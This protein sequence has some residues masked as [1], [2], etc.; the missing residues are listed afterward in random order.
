MVMSRR[1]EG[2]D[3]HRR[4]WPSETLTVRKHVDAYLQ[5]KLTIHLRFVCSVRRGFVP[6]YSPCHPFI[7]VLVEVSNHQ[8]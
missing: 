1:F 5:K 4:K 7:E 2:P 8:L 3:T 6:S